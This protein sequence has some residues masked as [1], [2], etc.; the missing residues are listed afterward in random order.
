MKLPARSSND[1]FPSAEAGSAATSFSA[2]REVISLS[3][4]SWTSSSRAPTTRD[5]M[6][7]QNNA[8]N[9]GNFVLSGRAMPTPAAGGAYDPSEPFRAGEA[10]RVGR[11]RCLG[12]S[13]HL[14]TWSISWTAAEGSGGREAAGSRWRCRPGL[15]SA[16]VLALP[17]RSFGLA[18]LGR[19]SC[20]RGALSLAPSAPPSWPA[21]MTLI[22]CLWGKGDF[23]SVSNKWRAVPFV[24]GHF[25][26]ISPPQPAHCKTFLTLFHGSLQGTRS[27]LIQYVHKCLCHHR[28]SPS[29]VYH[30]LL[31]AHIACPLFTF[32]ESIFLLLSIW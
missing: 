30:L 24:V 23:P 32:S 16:A 15:A 8:L 22:V 11:P 28:N 6:R 1:A 20:S 19:R 29:C 27:L 4:P 7:R 18:F 10:P 25:T 9:P 17:S 31:A 2:S 12:S 14:V 3:P 5:S 26:N 21:R 13:L